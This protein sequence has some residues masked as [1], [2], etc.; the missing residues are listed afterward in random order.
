MAKKTEGTQFA[1]SFC[2]N[3]SPRKLIAG[4][5]IFICD[6]C[7]ARSIEIAPP[8]DTVEHTA[9]VLIR[10]PGPSLW[11]LFREQRRM[12]PTC[13]FCGKAAADLVNPQSSLGTK[14]LICGECR[15]LCRQ[16][17]VEHLG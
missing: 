17:I 8:A 3:H 12:V 9:G 2:G 16:I 14:E 13:S 5:H 1:C 4:P 10:V 15:E 11:Q 7:V 6:E